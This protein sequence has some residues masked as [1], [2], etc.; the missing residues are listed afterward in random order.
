MVRGKGEDQKPGNIRESGELIPRYSEVLFS[1]CVGCAHNRGKNL[2]GEY[3][4]KPKRYQMRS[5]GVK[6]PR[7]SV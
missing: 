7:R 6:C 3:G 1:Q 4:V 2:C 5:A